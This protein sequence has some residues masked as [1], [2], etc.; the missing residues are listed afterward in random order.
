MMFLRSL[1]PSFRLRAGRARTAAR[2]PI[3]QQTAAGR[4]TSI[5]CAS[6]RPS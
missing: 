5:Q 4:R 6:F 2:A 3:I 1:F